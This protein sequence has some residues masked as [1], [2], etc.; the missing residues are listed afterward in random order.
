MELACQLVSNKWPKDPHTI[1]KGVSDV[2]E[3]V[4]GAVFIDCGFD[5]DA[6]AKVIDNI[7]GI[8]DGHRPDATHSDETVLP[9][10]VLGADK[11]ALPVHDK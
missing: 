1:P 11:A 6:V 3:A 10:E 5:Y 2:L 9:E 4:I 7:I 8:N